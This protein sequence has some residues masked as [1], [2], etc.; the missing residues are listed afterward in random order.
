[1]VLDRENFDDEHEHEHEHEHDKI[2]RASMMF[3]PQSAIRIPQSAIENSAFRIP[4]LA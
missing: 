1:M 2:T 3:I 4:Q